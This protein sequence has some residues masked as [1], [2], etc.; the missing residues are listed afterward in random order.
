MKAGA[1]YG[2]A[3]LGVALGDGQA[4]LVMV[5]FL[6]HD[7]LLS[8]QILGVDVNTHRGTVT[9]ETSRGGHLAELVVALG[10]IGHGDG[11]VRLGFLGADDLSIPQ[12][13][14]K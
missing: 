1:R 4:A 7:G 13:D 14:K 8:L 11:A 12:D 6:H 3:G 2:V 9:V 5:H 10:D